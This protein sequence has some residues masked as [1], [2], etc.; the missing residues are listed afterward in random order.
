M[1]SFTT[2]VLAFSSLTIV[3]ALTLTNPSLILP[4][5]TIANVS[6]SNYIHRC[7]GIAYGRDLDSASCDEALDQIDASSTIQQTYGQRL[8]G[9]F[10]VKLPKRYIS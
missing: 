9:P 3:S 6:S 10:D 5:S 7:D 8:T 1:I 4:G 2:F